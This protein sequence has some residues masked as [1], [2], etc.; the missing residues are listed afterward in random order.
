MNYSTKRKTSDD[1]IVKEFWRNNER[2]AD[3]FNAVLFNGKC[4]I[5]ADELMEIDTD[6][7]GTIKIHEYKETLKRT[8]DVVKKY[9]NGVEFNILGLEMQEKI[10]LAMP[11]RTMVYDALGYIKEY[12]DFKN[13]NKTK[14]INNVEKHHT[15]SSEEFLSGLNYSDRFHPIIT[16]VFYYGEKR[17]DGPIS[18][19]DMMVNMSDEIKKM[20]NDYRINLVQISDAKDYNFNNDEVKALF[21]IM[22][23]IYNNDFA[24]ISDNYS[25]KSLSAELI[26]M[27]SEMTGT[28]ELTKI[29]NYDKKD[30][31]DVHMWKAMKDFRDSGVQEGL[32]KGRCEGQ[33][34]AQLNSI[35]TIMRKLNQTADEAMDTLDIEP[36]DREKYHKLIGS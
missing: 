13:T 16:I 12:N 22:R 34:Q 5:K 25:E 17:W 32:L 6:V 7:S 20:F 29:I 2:F 27:I 30:K 1:I 19:S 28:S 35:K 9:Y 21:D 26:D 24:N 10:H 15:K 18:L 14:N 31:E 3:L 23:S 11:L 36:K 33:E 8:R 4:I